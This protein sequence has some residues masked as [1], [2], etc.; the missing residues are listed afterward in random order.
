[1]MP[2]YPVDILVDRLKINWILLFGNLLRHFLL[3][4]SLWLSLIT[5]VVKIKDTISFLRSL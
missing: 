4:L 3:L 1:M 2:P 5:I